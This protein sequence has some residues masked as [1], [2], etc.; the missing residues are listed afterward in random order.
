MQ[1]LTICTIARWIVVE[2]FD[3]KSS[4]EMYRKMLS[5]LV[6]ETLNIERDVLFIF[7][8]PGPIKS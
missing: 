5:V 8:L 4:R 2:S 7:G 6:R 1:D 3:R